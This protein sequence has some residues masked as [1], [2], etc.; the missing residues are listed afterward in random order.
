[1]ALG[2][3]VAAHDGHALTLT[4]PTTGSGSRIEIQRAAAED[5]AQLL[6]G[7]GPSVRS[8]QDPQRARYLGTPDLRDGVDLSENSLLRLRVADIPTVTVASAGAIPQHTTLAEVVEAI[9]TAIGV[10]VAAAVGGRLQLSSP[11]S[12]ELSEV[13]L[14]PVRGDASPTLLGLPPRL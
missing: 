12:G 14:E 9:N 10:P 13:V 6:L 8:G 11:F 2:V 5:A 7:T 1:T 4:S 3:G